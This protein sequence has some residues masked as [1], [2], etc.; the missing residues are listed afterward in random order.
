MIDNA[1]SMSL[2]KKSGLGKKKG[3]KIPNLQLTRLV[4]ASFK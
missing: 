3:N 4:K 2:K 1:F